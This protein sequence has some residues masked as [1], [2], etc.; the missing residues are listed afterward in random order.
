MFVIA[1]AYFD[2]RSRRI[3]NWLIA[4]GGLA[5]L[6][7]GSP[8]TIAAGAALAAAVYLPLYLLRAL[9]AGDVKLMLI[10]GAFAGP[11]NWLAIFVLSALIGGVVAAVV[12]RSRLKP[13]LHGVF[14]VVTSLLRGKVPYREHPELDVTN[15]SSARLPHAVPIALATLLFVA[16]SRSI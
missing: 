1:A 12:S 11:Q 8:R 15:P 16:F 9:G 13:T 14:R 3:P 10:V 4:V 6:A 2:V 5:A 7:S